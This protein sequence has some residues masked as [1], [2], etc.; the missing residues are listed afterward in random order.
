MQTIFEAMGG[1]YRQEGDYL[2]PNVNYRKVRRS[3]YG[4]SGGTST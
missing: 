2:L 3:A 4:V 1:I